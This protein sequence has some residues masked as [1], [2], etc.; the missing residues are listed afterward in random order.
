MLAGLPLHGT[1]VRSNDMRRSARVRLV[2]QEM[3]GIPDDHVLI[4]HKLR[5][6]LEIV[7]VR[8]GQGR[9]GREPFG[10]RRS[11]SGDNATPTD[12]RCRMRLSC[13]LVRAPVRMPS[14]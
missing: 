4:L 12:R 10:R 5:R 7:N 13:H 9:V 14:L 6:A 8:L 11:R 3:R 2:V 1:N